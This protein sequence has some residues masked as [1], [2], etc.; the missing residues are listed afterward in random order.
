MKFLKFLKSRLFITLTVIVLLIALAIGGGISY[1]DTMQT[2]LWKNSVEQ[3]IEVT[4]QGCGAFELYIQKDIENIKK[5]ARHLSEQDVND[6]NCTPEINKVI[7]V[8]EADSDA[9]YNFVLLDSGVMYTNSGKIDL[10]DRDMELINALSTNT[11]GPRKSYL[12]EVTGRTVAGAYA[13]FEFKDGTKAIAQNKRTLSAIAEKFTLTFFNNKGFSYITDDRGNIIMRSSHKNSNN[14]FANILDDIRLPENNNSKEKS[15]MFEKCLKEN[16][17]GAIELT[18]NGEKNIVAFAPIK[19]TDSTLESEWA[20]IVVLPDAV[21]MEHATS[22]VKSQQTLRAIIAVVIAVVVMFVVGEQLS[23]RKIKEKEADIKYREQLFDILANSTNDVYIMLTAENY[24]VEY[25]SP[26]VEKVLGIHKKDIESDIRVMG[27]SYGVNLSDKGVMEQLDSEGQASFD[28]ERRH[29]TTGELRHFR[30]TV[31]KTEKSGIGQPDRY[32]AVLSDRTKEKKD[33]EALKNALD[34]A[35]SANKA[36]SNFL[37]NMS[38]D[39]RTPMN[40]IIGF[41]TL[42][43]KDAENPEKVREYVKKIS[44]SGQ[45]LLSLINDILDMSKIESGKT[46]LHVEE[47]RLAEFIEEIYSMVTPQAKAKGQSFEVHSKGKLPEVISTDKLRLNQIILNL[48]SNAVKYTPENGR[49]ELTFETLPTKIANH[50]HLK[51]DVIDNGIGMSEEFVKKIFEPFTREEGEQVNKIQGTGLGMAITHNIVTLMGGTISV[52]SKVGEG[53]VFTVELELPISGNDKNVDDKEFWQQND[54]KRVLVVDDDEDICKGVQSLMEGS[55]VDVCYTLSGKKAI[56]LA[57]KALAENKEYDIIIL[58]WRMPEMDGMETAKQ[59]RKVIKRSVPI[60]ILTSYSY[61]EIKDDAT[62]AGIDKL[63]PKPFFV[64]NLRKAIEQIKGENKKD[65]AKATVETDENVLKDKRIL[66][67]DDNEINLEIFVDLLE[68]EGAKITTA[69]NGQD[70]VKKFEDSAVG[71]FELIFM[72]VQ[73][74]IMNG[75]DATRA[76][77]AGRHPQAKTIPIIALTANAFDDDVKMS[78]DAG[79]NSHLAK[80]IDMAKVKKA[81]AL[82]SENKE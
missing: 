36:K 41:S 12:D 37:S 69:V 70:A 26:N 33:E 78:V 9:Q 43:S 24:A 19:G 57:K 79:M 32:V 55:G 22:I 8:F 38:H 62:N 63:M 72:D 53:S 13:R 31:Y 40:A 6:P 15:D 68:T 77:R 11:T 71:E 51:I 73:M 17:R 47:F 44:V 28:N 58:D 82:Y 61:E 67:V 1:M 4:T 21:L 49:V 35:K 20:L 75:H 16:K 59:I 42:I 60:L 76:I 23:Y 34:I 5:F 64:S 56:D 18:I 80:P 54:I 7:E 14:S 46:S 2:T 25:I 50:A 52:K 66:V 27:S 3:V 74:P 10:E 29:V 81:V 45:H 30:E 39:I 48:L 65:A